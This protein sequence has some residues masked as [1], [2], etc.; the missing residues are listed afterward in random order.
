M[1]P[2]G[3]REARRAEG[4]QR[5]DWLSRNRCRYRFRFPL[6]WNVTP[7]LRPCP[8]CAG[9]APELSSKCPKL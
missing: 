5:P 2:R 6:T 3:S 1:A 8:P 7:P 9:R 4:Q